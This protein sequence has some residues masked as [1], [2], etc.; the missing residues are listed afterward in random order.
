MLSDESGPDASVYDSLDDFLANGPGSEFSNL[1]G[2]DYTPGDGG[3]LKFSKSPDGLRDCLRQIGFLL[4]RNGRTQQDEVLPINGCGRGIVESWQ[5]TVIPQPDGWVALDEPQIND[6]RLTHIPQHCTYTGE[7]GKFYKVVFEAEKWFQNVSALSA[8]MSI[9]PFKLFLEGHESHS[10]KVPK[11][12]GKDRWALLFTEGYGVSY[13]THSEPYLAHAARLLILPCIGRTYEPG[14]EASTVTVL[15]GRQGIGKSLCPK[16]LFPGPWR[17]IWFSDEIDLTDT[18]KEMVEKS[19]GFVLVEISELAGAPRADLQR[20]KAI[21][22]RLQDVVRLAYRR[23]GAKFPRR[24]H[25]VG[26]GNITGNGLLPDDEEHRRWWPVRIPDNCDEEKVMQWLSENSLQLWAQGLH[27]YRERGLR[28][29][30]NPKTLKGEQHDAATSVKQTNP[31]AAD[32]VDSM[33]KLPEERKRGG[34]RLAEMMAKIEAFG[35]HGAGEHRVP[36]SINEVATLLAGREQQTGRAVRKE[37][38]DRGWREDRDPKPPKG[39][40]RPRR[41]RWYPPEKGTEDRGTEVP[42]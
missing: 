8:S 7:N 33:E 17:L 36:R 14:I 32:L 31:G 29:W 34:M 25:F 24:H 26:T 16:F 35:A 37:L 23:N 9:D 18:S 1:P 20:I 22:S 21:I 5:A 42:L 2:A 3:G 6:L 11:W 39:E 38:S 12:D 10:V 40:D 41:W 19:Q 30:L 28:A 15:V 4:R 13:L 27:E